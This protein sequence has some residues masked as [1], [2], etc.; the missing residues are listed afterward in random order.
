MKRWGS[1]VL[2]VAAA[3]LLVA[4]C[5]APIDD[6]SASLGLPTVSESPGSGATVPG[7]APSP[8]ATADPDPAF[9]GLPLDQLPQADG[10]VE[11][12]TAGEVKEGIGFASTVATNMLYPLSLWHEEFTAGIPDEQRYAYPLGWMTQPAADEW[13]ANTL[14]FAA[15]PGYVEQLLT[16]PPDIRGQWA[17]PAVD[18][19]TIQQVSADSGGVDEGT[20]FPVL[21]VT[22]TVTGTAVYTVEGAD[23]VAVPVSKTTTLDLVQTGQQIETWK[24]AGWTGEPAVFGEPEELRS[25]PQ[26]R[27]V[28]AP[29]VTAPSPPA[30]VNPE[31]VVGPTPTAPPSGADTSTPAPG[32][33]DGA[34]E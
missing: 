14:T 31:D 2:V 29:Q 4:G 18:V 8:T 34:P 22:V 13:A 10:Q 12:F 21:R 6:D 9:E 23:P 17:Y 20:G 16:L 7:V 5:S 15:D 26:G 28:N 30:E 33:P 19:F 24:I 1:S 3:G 32:V 27:E 11:G 25:L